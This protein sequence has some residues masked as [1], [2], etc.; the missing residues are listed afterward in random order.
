MKAQA[1]ELVSLGT[2]YTLGNLLQRVGSIILLPIYTL[3]LTTE[4]FGFLSLVGIIGAIVSST[5]VSPAQ[6]ARSRYY[7]RYRDEGTQ[8]ILTSTLIAVVGVQA[9]VATALW[10]VLTAPIEAFVFDEAIVHGAVA[11]YSA[12]IFLSPLN[13]HIIAHLQIRKMARKYVTASILR[14]VFSF[15]PT[16]VLLY[17]TDMT[18]LAVIVGDI[19]G[20]LVSMLFATVIIAN[21]ISPTKIKLS[22]VRKPLRFGYEQI[23]SA[24]SNYIMQFGDR[25][26]IKMFSGGGTAAV[27]LFTFG[28]T[29]GKAIRTIGVDAVKKSFQPI[30]ME[31]ERDVDFVQKFTLRFSRHYLILGSIAAVSLSLFGEEMVLIVAQSPQYYDS[32]PVVP[33][34]V[35]SAF[36]HGLGLFLNTG[37]VIAEKGLVISKNL[38]IASV[39]NILLNIALVLEFG[40]VGAAAATLISNILWNILKYYS[41]KKYADIQLPFRLSVWTTSVGL[42]AVGVPLVVLANYPVTIVWAIA[43]KVCVVLV[44]TIWLYVFGNVAKEIKELRLMLAEV[45]AYKRARVKNG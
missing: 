16:V 19:V 30:L 42:L 24:Y 44:F 13:Q 29:F 4:E 35:M 3:F 17:Q 6:S 33:F 32:W 5:I 8:D 41:S 2:V 21:D 10:Y 1:K 20:M 43:I 45:K 12:V 26:I 38:V 25:I 22:A 11:L 40:F 23:V 14:F 31:R 34:G 27:G 28:N 18:V 37:V 7:Y 39:A 36:Q 15:I 9:V